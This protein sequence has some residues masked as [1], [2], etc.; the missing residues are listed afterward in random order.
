MDAKEEAARAALKYVED[1]MTLGLGSGSTAVHFI[2]LLG[3]RMQ[4][5][6][7]GVHGVP[8][9]ERSR[10]QAI[11]LNIPLLDLNEAGVLDLAVDGADEVDAGLNLI[12]GG[13]GALVREK[14]VAAA[15]R[16]FIVV[17]DNSKLKE[18]L[19]AFPLPVAVFP[20]GLATTRRR[21]ERFGVEMSLRASP[22]GT[23]F[24]TDD[25]LHILDMKFGRISDPPALEESLKRVI[26]VADVGLFVGLATRVIL[27]SADGSVQIIDAKEKG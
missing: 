12:K 27:A 3:E 16:K 11:E 17:C 7:L 1:G 24:L 4:T 5:E 6:G 10:Q 25:G 9:S 23:P 22:A 14:L 21:L 26:G 20:F 18:A 2:R 15:S 8:T 13:G 19:G